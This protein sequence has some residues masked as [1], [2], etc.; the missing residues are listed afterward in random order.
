MVGKTVSHYRVLEKV[1]GGGMGVVYKAEDMRLGRTVALKFL[2]EALASDRQALERF[3]REARAASSLNHPNICTIHDIDEYEGRPFIA[4]ELL[5]GHTLRHLAGTRPF[6]TARLLE[7]AAQ[8]ADAL[9]AAHTKGIVHRDIKPANIFVTER[10]QAKVL[11]FGL[12]KLAEEAPRPTV[13]GT[14]VTAAT[15]DQP[16]TS[17]G[18][19]M[20]TAD[21]MSPEQARGE[22]LDARTDLFSFGAV[23]FEMATGWQAFTGRTTAMLHDA[24]LNREPVFPD[25]SGT[26]LPA[27]LERII[28]KALEKDREARYQSAKDLLVDLRRL[29]RDTES[30]RVEPLAAPR[31]SR[32]W[33]AAV[34]AAGALAVAAL[35][36]MLL[37][38]RSAPE[39]RPSEIRSL[40]ILPLKTLG[41]EPDDYLGLGI[42]DTIITKV[43][44]IGQ[45]TVR[46][47]SAVRRYATQEVDA[48]KAAQ[49]LKVDSVLDGTVQRAG[50]RLRVSVNLLR[51]R[52]GASLWAESFDL[53]LS[54]IFAMQDQ[55][56]QQVAARL[57]LKLTPTEQ[58]RLAKHHTSSPEAYEYYLK[59]M[60]SYE[61]WSAVGSR[62]DT[63]AAIA[64]FKKAIEIDP[65]YASAHA[66]LAICYT[67]TLLFFESDP[68][69]LEKVQQELA[70]AQAL[71]PELA[72]THEV[73]AEILWSPVVGYRNEE[74]VRE[75]L[76]AQRL[77]P[78]AGHAQ[79]GILYAHLGLEEPAMRQLQRGLEIDPASTLNQNRRAE[80]CIWSGK[81]DE[82]IAGYDRLIAADPTN[83]GNYAFSALACFYRNDL[84][85]GERRVNQA[86][87]LKPTDP[88]ALSDR[89][90]LLGLR[91]KFREAQA[92]IPEIEKGK[93]FRSYHHTAYNIASVYALQ[94]NGPVAAD[95]LRR[96]AE[97]GMPNYPMFARDPH[98]DRIRKDPAFV[99]FMAELRPRWESR[100]REF[101][102]D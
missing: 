29:K 11:D 83:P 70:Q 35:L 39:P 91:G 40:A 45:L 27:E 89:A 5:E 53:R 71:D 10:G 81:Y 23:L 22:E 52:D 97:K 47:T 14:A 43:S 48:M 93:N 51:T 77:N 59:G 13:S 44:Q 98:L 94:G 74:A 20:G 12:A 56:S 33:L 36:S 84:V 25:R 87:A 46:P 37:L 65:K 75:L 60:Q 66:R 16:L 49:E 100:Q 58:A 82:A 17:P 57:R 68:A 95:W 31:R 76:L 78:S 24:I 50:D 73:R 28:R 30:G 101:G 86:L 88:I 18:V 96:V 34:A 7:L 63:D 9:D 4:M 64:M 80:N 41:K 67:A 32:R 62:A 55:V 26:T 90:L 79:L 69:W 54:D 38:F 21:Y 85:E 42:A 61:K 1:G 6:A 3:R 92:F 99:Q 102:K 2:P 15:A 72:E 8:V 19:V